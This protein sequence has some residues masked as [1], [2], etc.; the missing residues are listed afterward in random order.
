MITIGV[1]GPTSSGKSTLSQRVSQK[2]KYPFISMDKIISDL[3]K[4]NKQVFT[5]VVRFFPETKNFETKTL[6]KDKLRA[7][8]FEDPIKLQKL[9]SILHPLVEKKRN[10]AIKWARRNKFKGIVFE[11]PLLFEVNCEG[12]MD[13]IILIDVPSFVQK[14]R[15]LKRP[16][17]QMK[18]LQGIEKRLLPISFKKMKAS[19]VIKNGLTLGNSFSKIVSYL[20]KI[21][22]NDHNF[23][24]TRIQKNL[25]NYTKQK[26]NEP[27][28]KPHQEI[29]SDRNFKLDPTRYGDWEKNGRAI[30]F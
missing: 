6:N 17:M 1:T 9:E 10:E 14:E 28:E 12:E 26:N 30:D 4:N 18:Y 11:I 20:G 25:P 16:S 24:K 22:N 29:K 21:E 19:I 3:L 15:F 23:K 13:Y 2:F 8:V 5:Q 27:L 7:I